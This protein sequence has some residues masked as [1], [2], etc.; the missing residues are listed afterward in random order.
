M[1]KVIYLVLNTK[2]D[3]RFVINICSTKERAEALRN[4]YIH[5]FYENNVYYE[6]D[7]K[8]EDFL[9]VQEV[10]LDTDRETLWSS[11]LD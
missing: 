8:P 1:E 3:E 9:S 4:S 5:N 11:Y 2:D 7:E 10:N 6:S